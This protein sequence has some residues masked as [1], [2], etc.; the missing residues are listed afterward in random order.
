MG[1][2]KRFLVFLIV[3]VSSPFIFFTIL[4]LFPEQPTTPEKMAE[5]LKE[6]IAKKKEEANLATYIKLLDF[7]E[8]HKQEIVDSVSAKDTS[9][10]L[11]ISFKEYNTTSL[12]L[13]EHLWDECK[14]MI[15]SI[16]P[17]SSDDIQPSVEVCDKQFITFVTGYTDRQNYLYITYKFYLNDTRKKPETPTYHSIDK[18]ILIKNKY[19]LSVGVSNA[20]HIIDPNGVF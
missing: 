16:S 10:C 18:E 6:E 3:A 4:R 20:F 9:A 2:T 11:T 12:Q 13:P 1:S 15:K 17:H 7:F 8:A 5:V 14:P 19:Y